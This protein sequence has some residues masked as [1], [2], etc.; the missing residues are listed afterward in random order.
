MHCGENKRE[1]DPSHMTTTHVPER[2]PEIDV[3]RGIAVVMMVVFHIAFDLYFLAILPIPADSLPWRVFAMATAGLFLALVG[4]SLSISAYHARNRLS[5]NDFIKKYLARGAGIFA[6]GMAITLV[7]WLILPGYFILFGIL[8]LIGLAIAL[9]PLYTGYSWQNLVAGSILILL[10]P[11][12][13]AIRGNGW[14]LWLGIHPSAFYSIDYTPV[15]PWL[16]VVLLGVSFGTLAYPG[17]IRKWNIAIPEIPGK[18]LGLLG[19]HSLA[20][21]LIHQPIILGILFLFFP[22]VFIPFLP[23]RF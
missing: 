15:V 9:S 21:Y 8:H 20:I 12:V 11:V 19:R 3:A 1:E 16:G 6:I 10:G 18:V 14:L 17:G 2:F 22:G 23:A 5:R 13:A 4:I 7:T